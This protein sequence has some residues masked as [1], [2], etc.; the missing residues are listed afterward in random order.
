MNP[1]DPNQR[2]DVGFLGDA[3]CFHVDAGK[4]CTRYVEGANAERAAIVAWLKRLERKAA[5]EI[6]ESSSIRHLDMAYAGVAAAIED[7]VHLRTES[8][9]GRS[10]QIPETAKERIAAFNALPREERQRH[11]EVALR[12]EAAQADQKDSREK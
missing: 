3:R 10:A 6:P 12:T 1:S 9:Q 2:P 4:R 8:T 7:G 5:K 11:V